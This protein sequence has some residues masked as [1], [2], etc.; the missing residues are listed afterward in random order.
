MLRA[1]TFPE[2]IGE[3]VL[4]IE[5]AGT[6]NRGQMEHFPIWLNNKRSGRVA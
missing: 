2:Q 5:K 6:E 4:G 1:N 3:E